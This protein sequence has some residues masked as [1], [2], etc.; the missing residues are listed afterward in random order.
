MAVTGVLSIIFSIY[1]LGGRRS[2]FPSAGGCSRPTPGPG[3]SAVVLDVV[4]LTADTFTNFVT[5]QL[6]EACIL[7]GLCAGECSSS[8]PIMPRW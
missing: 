6:I 1:M 4:H 5:G 7:G 3:T 8:R 2:C